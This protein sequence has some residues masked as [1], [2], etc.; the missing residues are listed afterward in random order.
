ML[1]TTLFWASFVSYELFCFQPV[2]RVYDIPD[3]TFESDDDD[4]SDSD[5]SEEEGGGKKIFLTKYP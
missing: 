1:A 3:N 4:D 2:L 5:E